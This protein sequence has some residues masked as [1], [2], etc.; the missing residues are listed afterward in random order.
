MRSRRWGRMSSW[1]V[2][3]SV[4]R[5]SRKWSSKSGSKSYAIEER[6]GHRRGR[7]RETTVTD[8]RLGRCQKDFPPCKARFLSGTTCIDW[9]HVRI[10]RMGWTRGL[11]YTT[12]RAF[13]WWCVEA[14]RLLRRVLFSHF[15]HIACISIP[16]IKVADWGYEY[17]HFMSW[18]GRRIVDSR[19]MP[20]T[21]LISNSTRLKD[22][23]HSPQ[24]LFKF[25]IWSY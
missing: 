19:S 21:F 9:Q 24:N 13:F 6:S 15:F 22:R 20:L 3:P 25:G 14:G 11:D 16:H 7:A 17:D 12:F 10:R 23:D 5:A 2:R 4:D 1:A 8:V 18:M